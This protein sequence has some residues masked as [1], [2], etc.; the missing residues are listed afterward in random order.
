MLNINKQNIK[1][2]IYYINKLI[3]TLIITIFL[4]ILIFK[5]NTIA[6]KII[7]V[8]FVICGIT[9]ILNA[10]FSLLNKNRLAKISKKIYILVFLIYWFAILGYG[11]YKSIINRQYSLFFAIIPLLIGGAYI[12]YKNIIK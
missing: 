5:Q 6:S 7:I 11:A 2:K 1:D 8:P 3:Y 9:I 4:I 12:I 10:V